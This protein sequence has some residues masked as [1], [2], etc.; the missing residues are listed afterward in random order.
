[1][2][3]VYDK[4]FKSKKDM[5]N[6]VRKMLYE[7][8][9]T[10]SVKSINIHFYEFLVSL[11]QRHPRA[12]TKLNNIDDIVIK[13]D[14]FGNM[15]TDIVRVDGTNCDISWVKCCDGRTST[16]EEKL[17]DAMRE[18]IVPYILT[19]KSQCHDICNMCQ[20]KACKYEIDHCNIPFHQLKNNFMMMFPNNFTTS[21]A[22]HTI[23][24]RNILTDDVF[25]EKWINYHNENAT[26][27]QL[28][29]PCHKAKTFKRQTSMN[30]TDY[31]TP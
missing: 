12:E 15:A 5:A 16:Y 29:I 22:S 1:M 18:A 17:N 23:T 8:G 6:Y 14:V 13:K 30:F 20:K 11:F 27:Q 2:Y 24:N 4:T 31:N 28:C 26:L 21:I 3:E 10:Q 19:F 7:I 9:T 25:K